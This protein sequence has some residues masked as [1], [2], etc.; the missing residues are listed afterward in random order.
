LQI[1]LG[2]PLP[3]RL[4]IAQKLI[5]SAVSETASQAAPSTEPEEISPAAKWLLSMAGRYSGGPG[6]TAER[7]DEICL[8]EINPRSGFTLKEPLPE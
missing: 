8:A 1:L 4:Q 5:E 7:A 2:L 3:E 6:D